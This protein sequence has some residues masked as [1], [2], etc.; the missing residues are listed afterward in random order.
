[1]SLGGPPFRRTTI[2]NKYHDSQTYILYY[3]TMFIPSRHGS[4][5]HEDWGGDFPFFPV[6]PSFRPCLPSPVPYHTLHIPIRL[7]YTIPFL[8]IWTSHS[9]RSYQMKLSLGEWKTHPWLDPSPTTQLV[10]LILPPGSSL[11]QKWGSGI[12][13][14]TIHIDLC[15]CW[16]HSKA[17]IIGSIWKFRPM[18]VKV[19]IICLPSMWCT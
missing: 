13:L 15:Y 2:Q 6:H 12:T 5:Y 7:L 10:I 18:T 11:L 16:I 3:A 9:I 1:M 17:F 19:V 4:V 14:I 8:S